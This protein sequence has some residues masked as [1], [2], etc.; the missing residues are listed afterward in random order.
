MAAYTLGI[1][2]HPR[3]PIEPNPSVNPFGIPG[4][5]GALDLL[6]TIALPLLAVGAFGSL[7]ALV[8]RFRRS[9]AIEREQL[10][11]L[12]YAGGLAI[13]GSA[14][15][16]VLVA[17]WPGDPVVYELGITISVATLVVIGIAAGIAI[18][19]HR[20]YNIDFIINRT[21][22]YGGLTLL[23]VLIYTLTVG[24]IGAALSDIGEF[25]HLA[26]GDGPDCDCFP[27][28]PRAAPA[29]RQ[30]AYVRPAR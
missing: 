5:A 26:A 25:H 30:S 20:L 17:V 1:A 15:S 2:L 7:A 19:R 14:V 10:K 28:G 23:V 27:A 11:W 8:V 24:W 22:V 6:L 4:A 9:R 13:L 3:P 18:L 21:L 12:A 29:Q 16:G